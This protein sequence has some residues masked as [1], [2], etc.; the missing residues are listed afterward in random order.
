MSRATGWIL[1]GTALF[2]VGGLM[3]AVM[4]TTDGAP[5]GFT[6]IF[7]L[8]AIV[9]LFAIQ[10]GVI[11]LAVRIGTWEVHQALIRPQPPTSPTPSYPPPVNQRPGVSV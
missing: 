3:T 4:V 7:G 2:V 1:V 8:A 9:G 6:A 10:V 5:F 11:A